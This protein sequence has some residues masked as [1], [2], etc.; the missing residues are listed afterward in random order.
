[1]HYP[2]FYFSL[3]S[4]WYPDVSQIKSW[5]WQKFKKENYSA[6]FYTLPV[7][8]LSTWLK[9][10]ILN[11]KKQLSILS[12]ISALSSG[13]PGSYIY[14]LCC[15]GWTVKHHYIYIRWRKG[16]KCIRYN[17]QPK[18]KEDKSAFSICSYTHLNFLFSNNL[19]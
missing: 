12:F 15:L 7:T 6:L 5:P 4:A 10:C 2:K 19:L 1:M 13:G 8:T 3:Y 16:E 9:L 11:T 17:S 14:L 18:F